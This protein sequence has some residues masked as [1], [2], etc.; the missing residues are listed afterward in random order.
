MDS[1]Q[2]IILL[3]RGLDRIEKQLE[4]V[5]GCSPLTHGWQT[6]KCAKAS[7]KWDMLSQ[8]KFNLIKQLNDLII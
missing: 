5:R 2:T 1:E 4:K 6:Q 7:R 8:E 3:K